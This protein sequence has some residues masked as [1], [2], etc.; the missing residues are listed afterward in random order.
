LE[1]R[2]RLQLFYLAGA[3]MGSKNRMKISAAYDNFEIDCSLDSGGDQETND[4]A[5]A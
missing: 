4:Q 5:V 2:K 1:D 3:S